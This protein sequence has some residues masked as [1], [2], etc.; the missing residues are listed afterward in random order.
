MSLSKNEMSKERLSLGL[1]YR[2]R[3]VT[4]AVAVCVLLAGC[5]QV[6]DA[7]NP[8]AW[9]DAVAGSDESETAEP[10][11]ELEA[12]RGAPPPGSSEG[13]PN[14]ARVDQQNAAREGLAADTQNRQYAE[15]LSRQG[16]SGAQD[17]LYAEDTPPSAPQVEAQ[18]I[19]PAPQPKAPVTTAVVEPA[20]TSAPAAPENRVTLSPPSRPQAPT[21][22][23]TAAVP[24]SNDYSVDPAMGQRLA[25]Q[26]AEIRARASDQGSLLPSDLSYGSQ[27]SPTIVIS[28][29]GI[30]TSQP[31]AGRL[32]NVT[33]GGAMPA[34]QVL[35][36]G[37]LPLP[38]GSTRVAT[39]QFPNGSA[40]LSAYDRKILSDVAKLQKQSNG[41]LRIVGHSS[42]RTRNMPPSQHAITNLKVSE[43]R[44]N[45]VAN[46]LKQLGVSS[47]QVL[48]AAVG[49]NQP[50]FLE[51][52]PSGEAGNRRAE[53]YLTN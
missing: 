33:S 8:V 50:V 17:S 23:Q 19:A 44:A 37:A 2:L 24:A 39:I 6:P 16:S 4:P 51:V 12:G 35:N 9:Y 26:L 13:F 5:S 40:A 46:I 10:T 20:P 27:G 30:E 38:N 31:V 45:R 25:Q 29:G 14:L 18:Q 47:D 1:P 22:T 52:M 36:L 21:S 49:D 32:S 15:T 53:I 41:V 34:G 43:K 7:I 42:Q 3:L 11:N 28:S 48:V